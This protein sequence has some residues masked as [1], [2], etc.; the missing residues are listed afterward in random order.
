[1]C[2]Q[3]R[4]DVARVHQRFNMNVQSQGCYKK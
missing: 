1:L 3:A 2:E 4:K